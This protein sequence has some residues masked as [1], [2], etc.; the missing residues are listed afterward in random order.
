MNIHF[1]KNKKKIVFPAFFRFLICCI[2]FGQYQVLAVYL[3]LFQSTYHF[4]WDNDNLVNN[5]LCNHLLDQKQFSRTFTYVLISFFF[6][7]KKV[8]SISHCLRVFI[9]ILGRKYPACLVLTT[10]F[11][12]GKTKRLFTP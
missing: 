1:F 6:L 8:S 11:S 2:A 4:L 9:C 5:H 12:N 10:L 3:N 7:V